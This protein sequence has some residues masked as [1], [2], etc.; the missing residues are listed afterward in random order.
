MNLRQQPSQRNSHLGTVLRL[1]IIAMPIAAFLGCGAPTREPPA[2]NGPAGPARVETTVVTKQNLTQSIEM[3]GTIEGDETVDLYAKVGGFL[4]QIS[5]DIGDR[6]E[7]GQ[8]LARL[9]IPE[10]AKELDH[11]KAS[12]ESA[13]AMVQQTQAGI[14]QAEARIAGAEAAL[15]EAQTQRGEKVAELK[16]RQAEFERTKELVDKGSFLAK[17]LDEARFSLEASEAAIKSVEARVRSAEA[18][19]VAVKVDVEKAQF[20]S[21]SAESLVTVAIADLEKTNAMLDYATIRAPFA[22]LVTKRMVDPGAFIQ[23][24]LGNSG[25]KPLLTVSATSV[26]RLRLDLPMDEIQWL[27]R[28]DRAT[29]DRINALPGESFEG[30]VTRYSSMLDP[31]SRTM[32][33]EIDLPNEHHRL[34]PGYYGYVTLLLNEFEDVPTVP[35]SAVM[36]DAEGLF[37]YVLETN[38]CK[39]R[40]ITTSFADGAV[41]GVASGLVGGETVVRSGGGQLADGQQVT[42]AST[43][44]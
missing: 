27:D 6:V 24:A 38:I 26:V 14:R 28:G 31:T 39:R 30:T 29:F 21:A 5:V 35:A 7:A 3:S 11:Q 23:P 36:T 13:Q 41:V 18:E 37:V 43:S 25:A 17:K 33:V 12:V 40:A 4:E 2:A 34:S 32:R 42:S 16:L 44:N 8:V 19:L 9:S 1:G 22:G 15:V 20:D 10:M